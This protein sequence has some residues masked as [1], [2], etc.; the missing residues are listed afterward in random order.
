MTRDYTQGA[1]SGQYL[2][3]RQAPQKKGYAI[4]LYF[5]SLRASFQKKD[6][7]RRWTGTVWTSPVYLRKKIKISVDE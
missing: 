7:S 2:Y 3:P 4:L 1:R 6:D 5:I